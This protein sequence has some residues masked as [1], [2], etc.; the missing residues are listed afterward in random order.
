MLYFSSS[1][2]VPQLDCTWDTRCLVH[3]YTWP[4]WLRAFLGWWGCPDCI[5]ACFHEGPIWRPRTRPPRSLDADCEKPGSKHCYSALVLGVKK[6][7]QFHPIQLI[8][9]S[10][11]IGVSFCASNSA[12]DWVTHVHVRFH[13]PGLYLPCV[14]LL[15]HPKPVQNSIQ[16]LPNS[17]RV[18]P[19]GLGPESTDVPAHPPWTPREL[20]K[21]RHQSLPP[22][23]R[24]IRWNRGPSAA[25]AEGEVSRSCRHQLCV[26][27]FLCHGRWPQTSR[28]IIQKTSAP[29]GSQGCWWSWTLTHRL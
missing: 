27:R 16:I 9:H 12:A 15:I 4:G 5:C 13:S 3:S 29:K 14:Y 1:F 22:C 25:G 26:H 2:M 10:R 8:K 7:V 28:A 19:F 21:F 11:A 6:S 23:D 17:R 24:I 18:F 20:Q